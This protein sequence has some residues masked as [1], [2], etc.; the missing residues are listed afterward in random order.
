MGTD[1]QKALL[2]ALAPG[3]ALDVLGFLAIL[4][5]ILSNDT[6]SLYMGIGILVLGGVIM[7]FRLI[8]WQ[9]DHAGRQ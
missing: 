5:Y 9:R 1:K 7:A 8:A 2:V 6:N 4:N 3:L